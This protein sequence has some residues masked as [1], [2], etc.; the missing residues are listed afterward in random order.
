MCVIVLCITTLF[1]SCV[2]VLCFAEKDERI[3]KVNSK[4]SFALFLCGRQLGHASWSTATPMG[5]GHVVDNVGRAL[6]S[7]REFKNPV[8]WPIKTNAATFL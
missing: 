8:A 4:S 6:L 2:A 3:H 7:G 1:V 5:N